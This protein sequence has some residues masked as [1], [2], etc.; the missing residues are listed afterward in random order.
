MA[1]VRVFKNKRPRTNTP[2]RH[3]PESNSME[4]AEAAEE[5]DAVSPPEEEGV[6]G[7]AQRPL[8]RGQQSTLKLPTYYPIH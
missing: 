3:Q 2:V 4:Q 8:P 6:L 1:K 7:A 5:D